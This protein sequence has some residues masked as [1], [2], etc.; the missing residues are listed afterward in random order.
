MSDFTLLDANILLRHVEMAHAHHVVVQNAIARLT[1]SGVVLVIVPQCLYEFWAVA[2]RPIQNNGLGYTPTE[3][4]A[5]LTAIK[6]TFLLKQDAPE[7]YDEW[8]HL[9]S[10]YNVSGKPTHDARYVAAMK[11]HNI[12]NILTFNGSDFT[13]FA[14][15]ENIAVVDPTNV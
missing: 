3:T 10:T 5:L 8:Q 6:S 13:R 2:T 7:I 11:V 12:E 9:V 1:T 4:L 15:N 14:Q